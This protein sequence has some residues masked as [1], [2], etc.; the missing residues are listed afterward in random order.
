[1]SDQLG[2]FLLGPND[3]PYFLPAEAAGVLE[4]KTT[5]PPYYYSTS[6]VTAAPKIGKATR[7]RVARVEESLNYARQE[8]AGFPPELEGVLKQLSREKLDELYVDIARRL[9][10][11]IP[12]KVTWLAHL[13]LFGRQLVGGRLGISVPAGPVG[14]QKRLQSQ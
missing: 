3:T 11:Y 8:Y 13:K 9:R 5:L 7:T 4:L 14:R 12:Q 6:Q 10:D 1:M 2:P